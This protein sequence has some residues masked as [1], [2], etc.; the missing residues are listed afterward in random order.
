ML[1]NVK[2]IHLFKMWKLIKLKLDSQN[3][4]FSILLC[5]S[6]DEKKVCN[7]SRLCDVWSLLRA[8]EVNY[9]L[10]Y[11]QEKLLMV[12]GC[13]Q[14]SGLMQHESVLWLLNVLKLIHSHHIHSVQANILKNLMLWKDKNLTRRSNNL[15]GTE[16]VMIWGLLSPF[17][18]DKLNWTETQ[19]K[20]LLT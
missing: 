8:L 13:R 4:T 5:H 12:P 18:T 10:S 19:S 17:K 14:G 3:M 7:F 20:D 1:H 11:D 16:N 2:W 9:P 6:A 15:F